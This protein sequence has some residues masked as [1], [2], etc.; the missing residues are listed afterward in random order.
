M[1]SAQLEIHL[2][3]GVQTFPTLKEMGNHGE[4]RQMKC[5]VTHGITMVYTPKGG[6]LRKKTR[7]VMSHYKF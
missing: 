7:Q 5:C 6:G 3:S 4:S 1:F 2:T